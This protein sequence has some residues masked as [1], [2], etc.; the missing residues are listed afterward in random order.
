MNKQKG[1]ASLLVGIALG[2]VALVL[3]GVFAYQA[4]TATL[5]SLD[6]NRI[7]SGVTNS[8]V[9]VLATTTTVLAA[10]P[11]RVYAR[12]SNDSVAPVYI[13]LGSGA[14]INKGI[15]LD[16]VGNT[17]ST[18]SNYYE[19]GPDNLYVGLITGVSGVTST[20]NIVER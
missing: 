3:V 17:T 16:G 9:S 1:S 13:Y 20:V 12:I 11:G 4:P 5:G 10:N 15:R 2:F 14:V 18:A 6:F 19:I 8:S 7:E